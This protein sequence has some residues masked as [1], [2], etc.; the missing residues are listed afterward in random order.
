MSVPDSVLAKMKS[1]GQFRP[2]IWRGRVLQVKVT[3]A[4]DL[5]CKNCSVAVG[6]AKKLKRL[7]M[8]TPDQFRTALQSLKGFPGVI[9][10]FGGNPCIHPKFEELCQIFREEVPNPEQRGLWSNRLFG[11]GKVCRETFGPFCNLNVHG[12]KDAWDEIKRD[13]PEAR[14]LY[15]GLT[16]DS[17]HGPLFGSMLD[18][19]IPE[20]EMW[21]KVGG[22]YVNQTWSAEITVVN[23]ELAAYFCEIA[24][25]MAE[26]EG[27]VGPGLPA[28][29]GW[30]AKTMPEFRGQVE[31]YC[32]RC[33]VAMNPKKINAAGNDAEVYTKVWAPVLLNVNGRPLKEAS[34]RAE[35]EGGEPATKYLTQGV[36]PAKV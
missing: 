1:P 22:C 35:L 32:Q 25:T 4:C 13:W 3:N 19:G 27:N 26:L 31:H 15:S 18:L 14:P 28:T 21:E 9:G 24:G 29:P 6:I 36:M 20:A 30:W 17:H 16:E 23:G 33:L 12:S 8:M 5:D 34:T 7:F 10:M 11:H 2:G